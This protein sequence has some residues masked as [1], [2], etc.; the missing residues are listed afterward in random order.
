MPG[1]TLGLTSRRTVTF[2]VDSA[3]GAGC[4]AEG[5]RSGP[6]TAVAHPGDPAPYATYIKRSALGPFED[7]CRARGGPGN[8]HSFSA[9]CSISSFNS[10][11]PFSAFSSFKFDLLCS[12]SMR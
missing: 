12:A 11:S 1:P 9:F 8:I 5:S 4:G 10:F 2:L 6:L 7:S 3:P